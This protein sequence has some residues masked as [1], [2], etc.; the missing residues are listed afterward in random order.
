MKIKVT[1]FAAGSDF[2]NMG[3]RPDSRARGLRFAPIMS[4]ENTARVGIVGD[5]HHNTALY[6]AMLKT[7]REIGVNA[8]F[9]LGDYSS[10][11][12]IRGGADPKDLR[13]KQ[14]KKVCELTREY[15]ESM[16]GTEVVCIMGNHG[17]EDWYYSPD[18]TSRTL[19]A[20]YFKKLD[21][22]GWQIPPNP[23]AGYEFINGGFATV[24][25]DV[26][27]VNQELDCLR[28][29][30]LAHS[31]SKS[32]VVALY[33]GY[34]DDAAARDR[35]RKEIDDSVGVIWGDYVDIAAVTAKRLWADFLK[36]NENQNT[37]DLISANMR[38]SLS[39]DELAQSAIESGTGD[40]EFLKWLTELPLGVLSQMSYHWNWS[41]EPGVG[42]WDYEDARS[43]DEDV[44]ISYFDTLHA[45]GAGAHYTI[46]GHFHADIGLYDVSK[47]FKAFGLAGSG[48]EINK[49]IATELTCYVVECAF[50][51]D[52]VYRLAADS[53]MNGRDHAEVDL[54]GVCADF[55]GH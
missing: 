11:P 7:F 13:F 10:L 16:P 46:S 2:V 15:Q 4:F 42:L 48:F 54:S 23:L 17:I 33:Q 6:A 49:V 50:E 22:W 5:I 18:S 19:Y 32:L 41:N 8:I 12:T 14:F 1:E 24:F 30:N 3:H 26:A 9:L 45:A 21:D 34:S 20:K 47:S 35:H 53:H 38:R 31:I 39:F 37:I 44:L 43:Y 40:H 25:G 36:D 55:S 51:G 29:F 27:K 28:T 52:R